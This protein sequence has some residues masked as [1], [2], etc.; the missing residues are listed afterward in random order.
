MLPRDKP[1]VK[2]SSVLPRH[3]KLSEPSLIRFGN[4]DDLMHHIQTVF[5]IIQRHSIIINDQNTEKGAKEAITELRKDLLQIDQFGYM[6]C[7]AIIQLG[8]L[9]GFLPPATYVMKCLPRDIGSGS[10]KYISSFMNNDGRNSYE[11]K[12]KRFDNAVKLIKKL[13]SRRLTSAD[14]ENA[15]CEL[16]REKPPMNCRKKDVVFWDISRNRIQNFF[17][18]HKTNSSMFNSIKKY[19]VQ[20]LHKLKWKQIDN[21]IT[22]IYTRYNEMLYDGCLKNDCIA[23]MS[24]TSIEDNK[25]LEQH[26]FVTTI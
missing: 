13:S 20:F 10:N 24:K 14:I 25:L 3:Q 16:N 9:C 22:P 7:D 17:R 4:Q 8:A 23:V 15:M 1:R 21:E 26:P 5:K 2:G 18:I 6:T 12:K 19:K 11:E